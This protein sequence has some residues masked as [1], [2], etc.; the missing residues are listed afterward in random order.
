MCPLFGEIDLS[1][2]TLAFF[3]KNLVMADGRA[4]QEVS[5]HCAVIQKLG[6]VG[7]EG[8]G[9]REATQWGRSHAPVVC[10]GEWKSVEEQH[11]RSEKFP[12]DHATI[13]LRVVV[14]MEKHTEDS[15]KS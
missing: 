1:H 15:R 3:L 13:C 5:P 10:E 11:E 12:C 14:V 6:R 4:D 8:T 7:V 9:Y 2:A